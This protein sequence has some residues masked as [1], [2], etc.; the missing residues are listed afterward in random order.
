MA[1]PTDVAY[2]GLA[3]NAGTRDELPEEY[4]MAHFCEHM[5]FKG[6]ERRRAWHILNRMEAV[7]GDLNAYTTKEET[8]IYAAFMR[9]HL[10]RAIDLI[11]D[12]AFHS[13]YPQHEIEKEAEVIVEEIDSYKDTPSDLIFDDF[14]DLL[15]EGHPLGHDILGTPER[16]RSFRTDDALRFTRR[17]YQ[18]ERMV[19]FVFGRYDFQKLKAVVQ[20]KLEKVLPQTDAT[21]TTFSRPIQPIQPIKPFRIVRKL[22]THQ[23]HVMIGCRGY[24][25]DD[26]RRIALYF[27]NNLIGGPGMN[28]LLNVALREHQGLVYTVESALTNYTD[29]STFSIY[30]GCDPKDVE[31]CIR[32]VRKELNR[33]VQQPL[34]Q[35][36]FQAAL[37]QIRGQIGVACDNFENYALDM[38]KSYLHYNRIEGVEDTY[39][40]LEKLTPE[41]LQQV[42]ADLFTDDKLSVLIYQ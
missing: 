27:L 32:L 6:T 16:V 22:H 23:A 2:C 37:R 41:L 25:S 30:F 24:S 1:S 3:I 8:F 4:G 18:P 33:L 35:T 19:L 42:A 29:T 15:F 38:A 40:Q 14:E 34:T 26:K 13:T 9:E 21:V 5:L 10:E 11:L 28:S 7:G 12:V 39:R 20:R 31:H 36:R 17:L